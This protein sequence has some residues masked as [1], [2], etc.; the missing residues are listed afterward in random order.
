M[1]II[2]GV[3]RQ[4]QWFGFFFTDEIFCS[5]NRKRDEWPIL[6]KHFITIRVVPREHTRGIGESILGPE[7]VSNS[8]PSPLVAIG[9]LAVSQRMG[10]LSDNVSLFE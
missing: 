6:A 2:A 9:N 10:K 4:L 7:Y 3:A 1:Y 5:V 8:L